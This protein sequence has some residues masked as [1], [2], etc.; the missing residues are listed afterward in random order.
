MDEKI[1][2][3]T[4]QDAQNL[5]HKFGKNTL[6][7]KKPVG[8][9]IILF[10]QIK[11]PLIYIL[12][13][14]SFI[15]FVLKDTKDALVIFAAVVL[16]T[17]LG[18]Y[19]ERKAQKALYALK[20]IL[21]PQ[22]KVI[23]NGNVVTIEVELIVPGDV[24]LITSGDRIPADGYVFEGT[25]LLVNEAVLTGESVPVSKKATKSDNDI[26]KTGLVFMGTTVIGGRGKMIV[27]KTGLTTEFGN[28]ASELSVTQE[29]KTPLQ[30]KIDSFAKFLAIIFL[31]MSALI[32]LIGTLS[33][34]TFID[35]FTTS[36][37]VAVAAIPEGM[38]VSLTA[39]LAFG[40]QRILKRKA[41]VRKLV[42]AEALGS[43]TVIATD[44]TGTLTLGV[45]SVVKTDVISREKAMEA[46]IYANNREDALEIALWE[47]VQKNGIDPK[48][49][50]SEHKRIKEIPFDADKKYMASLI[51]MGKS[52]TI[53]VKGAPEVLLER[54]HMS[55]IDKDKWNIKAQRLG[56]QGLRLL[57]LAYKETKQNSLTGKDVSSLT[58][59]G[60]IGITDPVRETVKDALVKTKQ[61]GIKTIVITGDFTTTSMAVLKKLGISITG[62]QILEGEDLEKLTNQEFEKK[63]SEIIL[64]ARVSPTQKL[65]IVQALQKKGEVVALV[66]DGVNDAPAIKAA[67]IGIVV[68]GASDVARQTADMVLLDSNFET[69]VSAVEEGRGI[70]QNIKKVIFFLMAGSFSEIVLVMGALIL[71]FP[72]PITASQILWINIVTDGLPNLALTI[73]PKEKNLLNN[74]PILQSSQ[75]FDPLMK[76]MMLIISTV[77]GL[78]LLGLFV[79]LYAK[80]N[81][82][83][84]TRTI[85]FTSLGVTVLLYVFSVRT[86]KTPL[87]KTGLLVN[88]W[89]MVS[90]ILGLFIQL[91][92]LYNPLLRSFLGTTFLSGANF[93][94]AMIVPII[95]I[96]L[97]EFV[98]IVYIIPKKKATF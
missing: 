16:N 66:G 62:S 65:K 42:A 14:A 96:L 61:A 2:G 56:E 89:L 85:V 1:R 18:F 36:A 41:L 23:R 82:L 64:F 46:A 29:E 73:D 47:Y 94:Y 86:L 31:I 72:L 20:Q 87:I 48:K 51:Q 93:I 83:N 10:D 12:L 81:D 25:N 39:I 3:L 40:M 50:E 78:L 32:F 77:T 7:H 22:A 15:S 11:S 44:K 88:K 67:N 90:V 91:I 49:L 60:L 70:Y 98:K 24:L 43:T 95:I 37:A 80:T 92:P 21:S 33:G 13:I 52:N 9:L 28:I 68:A 79:F 76:M 45:M 19:Q 63:V 26:V 6:P 53:F 38:A 54:S 59:I 71:G 27:T 8:D 5:I 58:F 17:F 74:P 35:M 34:H 30:G 57:G 84:L 55:R 75:L 4:S 69:I 97:I